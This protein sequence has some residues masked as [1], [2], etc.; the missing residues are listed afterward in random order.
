M[1]GVEHW[2]K[3]IDCLDLLDPFLEFDEWVIDQV[4]AAQDGQDDDDDDIDVESDDE[5]YSSDE[6]RDSENDNENWIFDLAPML[7]NIQL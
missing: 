1:F 3:M 5:G 7:I 2:L 6:E 4:E